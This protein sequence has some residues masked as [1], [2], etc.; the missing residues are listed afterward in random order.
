M[1]PHLWNLPSFYQNLY[2]NTCA[3]RERKLDIEESLADEK[4][5]KETLQKEVEG[6]QKK[7]KIIDGALKNAESEL[8]AFQV[9]SSPYIQMASHNFTDEYVR[10]CNDNQRF[11]IVTFRISMTAAAWLPAWV[12]GGLGSRV[13]FQARASRGLIPL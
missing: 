4:K 5:N 11:H 3:L 8:E 7:A 1:F 12:L 13:Q 9:S 10:Y 6:L 2:D